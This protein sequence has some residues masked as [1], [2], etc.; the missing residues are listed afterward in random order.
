MN[1]KDSCTAPLEVDPRTL[2][3]LLR[4]SSVRSLRCGT[5]ILARDSGLADEVS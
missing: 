3:S 2:V 4:F 1:A 5:Q